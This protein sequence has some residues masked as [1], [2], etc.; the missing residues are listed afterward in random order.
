MSELQPGMLAL[1][2]GCRNV[3]INLGKIVTLERFVKEGQI[4][5][6]GPAMRDLWV[7]SGEGVGY[8]VGGRV[9][10]SEKG[11][12]SPKHLMPIKPEADPLEQKQQQELH[13]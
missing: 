4:V 8:F 10:I 9:V 7:I 11:L 5:F 13:A 3:E 6:D 1:V 12:A 2:I